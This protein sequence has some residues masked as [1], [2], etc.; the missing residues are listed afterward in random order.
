[1][2]SLPRIYHYLLEIS[3][4]KI[5]Y[6]AGFAIFI[7][8]LFS[9]LTF[10]ALPAKA[11]LTSPTQEKKLD[12]EIILEFLYPVKRNEVEVKI[13]PSVEFDYVWSGIL[14]NQKLRIRPRHLLQPDQSYQVIVKNIKNPLG[15]N[16]SDRF[17]YFRTEGLPQVVESDPEPE[18]GRI[19]PNSVFSFTL[20][21]KI[22]YGSF[23]L[24]SSPYFETLGWRKDKTLEFAPKQ[25]L[26]QGKKYFIGLQFKAEGLPI[27]NLFQGNFLVV[28]PLKVVKT[29]PREKIQNVSKKT[30][31]ELTF[32][33]GLKP[34][35]L[36]SYIKIKPYQE[37]KF[38]FVDKQTIKFKPKLALSTDT[39]YKIIVDRT[40]EAQDGAILEDDFVLR[41]KTAGPVSIVSATPSGWGIPL[42]SVVSVTFD[43]KVN[44]RSAQSKFS[45]SPKVAGS[46]S[47]SGNTMTFI[48][49]S[50]LN[51]FKTYRFSLDKEIKSPGGEPSNRVFSY[52]FRT[53]LERQKRIGTSVKGR[54]ITAYYFGVGPKKILL[55]GA[56]HG[57]EANTRQLLLNWVWYL[58]ANQN[59]VPAD[60]TFIIVP[61]SNPDGVASSSRFNAR[62]VDLNRNW[63]TPTWEKDSYWTEGLVK[64]GGGSAPFSEPE[65]KA[66]RDLIV[67]E[68]PKIAVSYHSAAGVVVG[69]SISEKFATWYASKTGYAKNI[70]AHEVFGYAIT[71]TLEEWRSARA[72]ITIVVELASAF[73][74]EYLRNIPAL[75]GLLTYPL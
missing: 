2:L 73:F 56:M 32:N 60:R 64:N 65:T 22:N 30:E 3:S 58:R 48:P 18:V 40:I 62:G 37:G 35:F 43:Q 14:I 46:F 72:K 11:S 59:L 27:T 13:A 44:K 47:W 54:A 53:T 28:K 66:L 55:V 10:L 9:S 69:D 23:E 16:E 68:N 24:I 33:K 20:D 52:N 29:S 38:E 12:E 50:I 42:A 45:I 7:I 39:N 70:G 5:P 25:I 26:K 74:S 36:A 57:T 31:V 1:M 41:F 8:I 6:A 71:G 4:K 51:L 34:L 21:K 63:D 17:F 49:G 61:N 75:K 15:I 19:K 67:A